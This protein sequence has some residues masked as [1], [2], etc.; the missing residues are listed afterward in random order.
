MA[1]HHSTLKARSGRSLS[2]KSRIRATRPKFPP[3]NP[4]IDRE[5][6]RAGLKSHIRTLRDAMCV[7]ITCCNALQIGRAHV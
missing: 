2:S 4:P 3:A 5:A 1:A 6:V 7:A